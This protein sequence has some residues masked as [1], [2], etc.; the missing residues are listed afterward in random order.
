MRKKIFL[1]KRFS[2]TLFY[3]FINDYNEYIETNNYK[4]FYN[5]FDNYIEVEGLDKIDDKIECVYMIEDFYIGRTNNLKLRIMNHIKDFEFYKD[6]PSGYNTDK[7][8]QILKVLSTRKLKVKI[9][10]YD[11]NTEGGYITKYYQEGYKLTNQKF[12]KE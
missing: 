1:P 2:T 11:R 5:Q 6:T 10:D 9:L 8:K 12:K 7:M 3:K 4:N